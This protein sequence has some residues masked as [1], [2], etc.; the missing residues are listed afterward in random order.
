MLP[1]LG[2]F[3]CLAGFGP[4]KCYRLPMLHAYTQIGRQADRGALPGTVRLTTTR[5][6]CP[7]VPLSVALY[8]FMFTSLQSLH[9]LLATSSTQDVSTPT[10]LP[11]GHDFGC[12]FRASVAEQSSLDTVSRRNDKL[13][14]PQILY[15]SHKAFNCVRLGQPPSRISEHRCS[16]WNRSVTLRN[17]IELQSASLVQRQSRARSLKV[18]SHCEPNLGPKLSRRHV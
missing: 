13:N 6:G 14:A 7:R 11:F 2:R 15:T 5:L 9:G 3:I 10:P 1:E 8:C 18:R 12:L 17:V 4:R 16:R